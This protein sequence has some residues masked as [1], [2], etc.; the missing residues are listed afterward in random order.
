M[1]AGTWAG[2]RRAVVFYTPR[3][4]PP[5]AALAMELL[6]TFARQFVFAPALG[7]VARRCACVLLVALLALSAPLAPA[8]TVVGLYEGTVPGDA[9]ET[10][11]AAAADAALRQVVVRVTGRRGAASDAALASLYAAA[12]RYVQTFRPAAGGLVTVGF[13]ADAVDAALVQAGQPLWG[14]NRPATLVVLV[15]ESPGLPPT[16]VG[17][18][19]A[20]EKRAADRAAQLRGV[21]LAWPGA[22]DAA[23]AGQ[24]IEAA[25]AQRGEALL[26]LATRYDASGVL[27]GRSA[28]AGVQWS[29][30]LPVG[31]GRVAGTAEDGVHAV[32]DRY[33]AALTSGQGGAI[34]LLPVVVTGTRGPADLAAVAAALEGIPNVRGVQLERASGSTVTFRVNFRGDLDALRRAVA[35]GG[36]L[37]PEE[38]E[39]GTIRFALQP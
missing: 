13:D 30:Y 4:A 15:L 18:A 21:P 6:R 37:V 10:G 31:Q 25:T 17:G 1:G 14:R 7:V 36:R 16:L 8:A 24:L 29:W 26:E 28:G 11:R 27:A 12:Q 38:G 20:D 5:D 22:V 33:A 34:A 39:P 19:D 35:A 2:E 3:T 23:V 9:S 32:A